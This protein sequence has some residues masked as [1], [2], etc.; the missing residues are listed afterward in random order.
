MNKQSKI[1]VKH[2][3]NTNSKPYIINGISYYSIYILLTAKR[4]NTKFKSFGFNEL[5]CEKDFEDILN[6]TDNED[7]KIITEEISVL[8][9][10]SNLVIN[11]LQDFDTHFVTA[12]FSFI[13]T[14]QIWDVDIEVFR[15]DDKYVNFYNKENNKSGIKLDDYKLLKTNSIVKGI[16]L[17]E[18]FGNANQQF[19]RDFLVYNDCKTSIEDTISDIN[20]IFFYQS[21]DKFKWFLNGSKKNKTLLTKYEVLFQDFT[22]ILTYSIIDKYMV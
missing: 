3:L 14:I 12:Y 4:Q 19:L 13:P 11:E 15:L 16:S 18:F 17:Y 21:F 8:E 6:L 22:H 2:Y 10:I 20:K 9:N 5:Y 7:K 1:T